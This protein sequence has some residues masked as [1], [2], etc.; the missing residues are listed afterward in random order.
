MRADWPS[1]V[2]IFSFEFEGFVKAGGLG[3]AVA[4]HARALAGAGIEVTVLVPSHGKHVQ[5]AVEEGR[6][7]GTREGVD[8]AS[9]GYS[10]SAE[11]TRI[12]GVKLVVF[13]GA[14]P[15]TSRFLDDPETYR[16]APEKTALYTRGAIHWAV[17][18]P[19]PPDIIHSNDWTAVMAASAIKNIY[20]SK[21]IDVPWVHTIHLVSSP[22]F[23]WHYA[24]E[25]WAGVPN[26]RQ[27]VLSHDGSYTAYTSEIWDGVGGNVDA[28]SATASDLLTSVSRGYLEYLLSR[29]PYVPREKTSYVYNST[30]WTQNE[31]KEYVAKAF[32]TVSRKKLR[33]MVVDKILENVKSYVG[34]LGDTEL[35][36]VAHG[37]LVWQ[38]GYDILMQS[39]DYMDRSL[40][41]LILGLSS[42]DVGHEEYLRR[43]AEQRPG[44]ILMTVGHVPQML[45]KAAIYSA[46]VA[47]VPSRYEPF[48]ISSI[49]SQA[50]GTPVVATSIPGLSETVKD[51]YHYDD[52]GGKLVGYEETNYLGLAI[53]SVALLTEAVDTRKQ[54][55]ADKIPFE[56]VKQRFNSLKK[57]RTNAAA[58]VDQNFREKNTLEQLLNCYEKARR[59]SVESF[60]RV[61]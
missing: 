39:V 33:K 41:V 5:N 34:G 3:A 43:L 48:G 6:W 24:S 26:I 47:A 11:S 30:D 4:R 27:S 7:S 54:S 56:F 9:Y 57:I 1:R 19:R 2:W 42:G 29:W 60:T 58:W 25:G 16:E 15:H 59:I 44:R 40:G 61:R 13:R 20:S 17:E 18:Q 31:V 55:L 32:G 38:K 8:G 50:L 10:V 46:N 51:I 22:S 37:R 49:E 35:L 52:G 53:T 12:D 45:L 21:N 36:A 14:D 28:Y 23:P